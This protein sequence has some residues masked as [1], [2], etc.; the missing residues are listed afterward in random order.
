[1]LRHFKELE[2]LSLEQLRAKREVRLA[3]FG[4]FAEN[5]P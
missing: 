4:V 1:V 2:A 5:E 3:S